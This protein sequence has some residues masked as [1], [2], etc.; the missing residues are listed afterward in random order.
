MGSRI[1]DQHE[2]LLRELHE[3]RVAALTRIAGTLEGLIEQL[4]ALRA[5]LATTSGVAHA[6]DLAMYRELRIQARK[7]RWYLDVQREALGLRHHRILDEMYEIPE[8]L[9]GDSPGA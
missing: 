9:D 3:E 1:N 8:A 5:R 6:R 2:H 4:K 7:Y